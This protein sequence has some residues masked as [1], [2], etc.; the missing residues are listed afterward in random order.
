MGCKSHPRAVKRAD[1]GRHLNPM[2]PDL[3]AIS[4]QATSPVRKGRIAKARTG[5]LR[6]KTDRPRAKAKSRAEA[7]RATKATRS[8]E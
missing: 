7:T 5:A 2:R 1:K 3:R 4:L 8:L 6:H